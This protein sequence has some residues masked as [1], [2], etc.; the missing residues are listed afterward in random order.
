MT[1]QSF[2]FEWMATSYR[3]RRRVR[4]MFHVGYVIIWMTVLRN[5]FVESK[6]VSDQQAKYHFWS[7]AIWLPSDIAHGWFLATKWKKASNANMI[8]SYHLT[9]MLLSWNKL[10]ELQCTT[11]QVVMLRRCHG[12]LCQCVCVSVCLFLSQCVSIIS[13]FSKKVD[14]SFDINAYKFECLHTIIL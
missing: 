3:D 5:I 9:H 11:W 12:C 2:V 1:H 7:A 8:S 14:P 6:P 4:K 10:L 13:V